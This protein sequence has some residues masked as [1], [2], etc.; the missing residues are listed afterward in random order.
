MK[1]VKAYATTPD[2][3]HVSIFRAEQGQSIT[4]VDSTPLIEI[5]G[6][7]GLCGPNIAPVAMIGLHLDDKDQRSVIMSLDISGIWKLK[8]LLMFLE[9]ELDDTSSVI[10]IERKNHGEFN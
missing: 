5:D 6:N 9:K 7:V 10:E 1:K 8:R 3:I 4:E 2:D